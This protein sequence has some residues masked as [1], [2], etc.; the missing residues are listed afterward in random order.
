VLARQLTV[1]QILS[2]LGLRYRVSIRE[3]GFE[4]GKC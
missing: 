1:S 4:G 3:G 2:A